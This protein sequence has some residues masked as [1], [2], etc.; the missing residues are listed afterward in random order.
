[1]TIKEL[2]DALSGCGILYLGGE[3][4]LADGGT[5]IYISDNEDWNCCYVQFDDDGN[6]I[7]VYN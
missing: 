7:G 6:C 3:S 2:L 4:S 5:A 1:M